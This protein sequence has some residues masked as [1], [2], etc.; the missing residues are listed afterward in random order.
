MTRREVNT[1]PLASPSLPLSIPLFYGVGML[2][3]PKSNFAVIDFWRFW[4]V[5]PWVEDFLEIFTTVTV[6]YMFVLI[7]TSLVRAYSGS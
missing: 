3:G 4:V 6:A 7:G 1:L 5:H 2:F